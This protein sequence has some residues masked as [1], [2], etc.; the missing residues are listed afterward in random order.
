[1]IPEYKG[2][3]TCKARNKDFNEILADIKASTDEDQLLIIK[4]RLKQHAE[5]IRY[6]YTLGMD[7]YGSEYIE[8][9]EEAYEKQFTLIKE[10]EFY[11][12]QTESI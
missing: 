12:N 4:A 1:M 10:G 2:Y 5:K 8:P 11:G 6:E 9:L 7:H 3:E